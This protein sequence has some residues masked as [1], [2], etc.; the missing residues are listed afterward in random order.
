MYAM[1]LAA[2][3][4]E[5]MRPLTDTL[6]KP[7]LC[8]D[9]KPLIVYHLEKLAAFGIKNIIINQAW[10][11]HKLPELLGNGQQWG[12]NIE[13]IDEGAR[14]LETAG[15]IKNALPSL[16]SDCF[17]VV[18]GDIWT[19]FDLADLPKTLPEGTLAHLVMVNNPSHNVTGDFSLQNERL[20]EV[21]ANKKT[22]AGIGLYR[23][24]LFDLVDSD[25]AALGPILRQAMGAQQ[26]QGQL[27]N[28]KW[29]D[30]GTPERLALLEQQLSNEIIR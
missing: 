5:R 22:F 9:D 10:L 23:H 7:L 19:D 13:Y 2:G 8:V 25:V 17:I 29:T 14:A 30:V 1:I 16:K 20:M 11:G 4:G 27:F 6:P 24:Q 21:G 18:N 12:V 3:R 28:G 26:I 15:G